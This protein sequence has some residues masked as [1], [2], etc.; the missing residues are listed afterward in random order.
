MPDF[1][2]AKNESKSIVK[3]LTY[4]KKYEILSVHTTYNTVHINNDETT[5]QV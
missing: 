5:F 3:D 2:L 4:K 1:N